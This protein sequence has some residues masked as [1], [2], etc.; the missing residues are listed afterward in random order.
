M[1][2]E[3]L[4]LVDEHDH[5][6]GSLPRSEVYKQKL[7]NYRVVHGF[8]VNSEGKIWIPRRLATK[9][10]YP[11][12][13]DYSVAGH[14]ESGESY[15]QSFRR[16]A[17]EELGIDLAAVPWRELGRY[18]P[19]DG[20]HCFFVVYEIRSDVAPIYN[21]ADFSEAVWFEPQEIVDLIEAAVAR[22]EHVKED[23]AYTIRKF[24]LST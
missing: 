22:G 8:V 17:K 20:A 18:S 14:V 23:V 15:E 9:K 11:N 4:D 5:V 12:T 24:Y 1:S 21:P 19:A 6:I 7:H 3:I 13:L 16:E 10:L 2:E